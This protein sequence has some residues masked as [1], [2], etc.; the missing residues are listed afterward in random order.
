MNWNP[1]LQ[2]P[3]LRRVENG[4]KWDLVPLKNRQLMKRDFFIIIPYFDFKFFL[5]YTRAMLRKGIIKGRIASQAKNKFLILAA[6]GFYLVGFLTFACSSSRDPSS[7]QSI[8]GSTGVEVLIEEGPAGALLAL[9]EEE[10][11]KIAEMLAHRDEFVILERKSNL[12]PD[13]LFG[14]NFPLSESQFVSFSLDGNKEVGYTL[15]PDI[16]ANGELNDDPGYQ[17]ELKQG[18]YVLKFAEEISIRR[19]SGTTSISLKFK[20]VVSTVQRP[21]IKGPHI[22]LTLYDESLRRGKLQVGDED[23]AF[24]L[25]GERG[26]YGKDHQ[27]VFFDM[28]G[29][30]EFD[31][32]KVRSL[33]RYLV[34][35]RF[36]NIGDWSYEFV[37]DRIGDTLTL[38]PLTDRREPR[39]EL[40]SGYPAPNFGFVD[41]EGVPHNLSDYRGRIVLLEFWGTW[42]PPCL[43]A[44]PYLFKAY[45]DFHDQ[46]FE[47]LGV[48]LGDQEDEIREFSSKFNINWSHT[49]ETE[50]ARPI[51]D[52]F[53]VDRWPTYF[54]LD[55]DG[56]IMLD[57]L[58]AEQLAK[59]LKNIFLK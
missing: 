16:N 53:R 34:S 12:S 41:L 51:H 42:C 47:I 44:A 24:V 38:L 19:D 10:Y 36:V 43:E 27:D 18:R 48:H 54:L 50:E 58:R 52:L 4:S 35:E 20:L 32:H 39:F 49:V 40:I 25:R 5:C 26:V 28:N 56:V 1:N 17:F 13:A 46:G 14:Y 29:D 55:G 59:K 23:I 33:E 45:A 31:L 8:I 9:S 2:K 6:V 57:E 3:W 30:G 11:D 37:V 21:G 7:G 22:N 15:I